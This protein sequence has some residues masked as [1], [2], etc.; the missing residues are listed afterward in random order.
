MKLLLKAAFACCLLSGATAVAQT[1]KITLPNSTQKATIEASPVTPQNLQSAL[2]VANEFLADVSAAVP[3][4]DKALL[5]K[6][7]R[8]TARLKEWEAAL[9]QLYKT[10]GARGAAHFN[11]ALQTNELPDGL[12][13][14]FT[15]VVLITKFEKAVLAETITLILE[16]SEYRI[17]GYAYQA[18]ELNIT[19]HST[20]RP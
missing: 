12:K 16:E 8:S 20:Q 17:V 5:Y 9:S 4:P 14:D 6:P 3:T 19:N 1:A 2:V 15:M 13:G 10:A 7:L 11:Q 18:A